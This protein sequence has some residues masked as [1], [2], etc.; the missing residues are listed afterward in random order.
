MRKTLLLIALACLL[1]FWAKPANA[2][3]VYTLFVPVSVVSPRVAVVDCMNGN[4]Y[5]VECDN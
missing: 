3:P 4:G 2:T 1:L 5:F